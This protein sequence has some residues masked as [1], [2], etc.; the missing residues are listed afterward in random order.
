MVSSGVTCRQE[1]SPPD[2]DR[3]S[4]ATGTC[5]DNAVLPN[6]LVLVVNAW[7]T[8]PVAIRAGIVAMVKTTLGNLVGRGRVKI[9]PPHYRGSR[10]SIWLRLGEAP[11]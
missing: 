7:E 3:P 8:L 11:R 9:P 2:K 1:S 4:T 5:G 10:S 6:D